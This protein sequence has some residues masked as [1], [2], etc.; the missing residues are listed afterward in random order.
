[1]KIN[2][3]Y[4][5]EH[6]ERTV[7]FYKLKQLNKPKVDSLLNI[8][9]YMLIARHMG[10]YHLRL[11]GLIALIEKTPEEYREKMVVCTIN[12]FFSHIKYHSFIVINRNDVAKLFYTYCSGNPEDYTFSN[13]KRENNHIKRQFK[14]RRNSH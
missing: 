7:G 3:E 14:K 6:G 13:W 8:V 4:I 9:N 2:G 5:L 11:A 12:E 10:K 1:V